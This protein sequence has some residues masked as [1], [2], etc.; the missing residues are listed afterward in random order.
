MCVDLSGAT[1]PEERSELVYEFAALG[2]ETD[3]IVELIADFSRVLVGDELR[4]AVADA[5][6]GART[7]AES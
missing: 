1:S 4:E 5:L 7:E 6:A 3:R 2:Y